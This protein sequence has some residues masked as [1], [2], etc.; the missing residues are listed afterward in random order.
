MDELAVAGHRVTLIDVANRAGVSPATVSRVLNNNYPVAASTRERVVEA[1]QHFDYVLNVHAGALVHAR[2]GILGIVV[3]DV[4]DP[5][6]SEIVRGAQDVAE[7]AGHLTMICSSGADPRQELAYLTLLRNH[8]ADA[9]LL[10]GAGSEQPELQAAL[11][12]QADGIARQGSRLVLVGRPAPVGTD[13]ASVVELDNHRSGALIGEHLAGLGHR[14]IRYL[15]G[16]TGTTTTSARLAGFLEGARAGGVLRSGVEVVHGPQNRDTGRRLVRRALEDG[17]VFSAVAASN[18]LMAIGALVALRE[19]GLRVPDDVSVVGI[20]DVPVAADV[21]PG[22]STVHLP[23]SELG[24]AAAEL[25]LTA[26]SAL[27]QPALPAYLVIR[28]STARPPAA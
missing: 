18:D 22:L 2:S 20:D 17:A 1:V 10:V 12:R 5:F 16:P 11:A 28:E 21:T 25:A 24:A 4:S 6:F 13:A 3:A 15:A 9:V 23:L 8:R 14:R 27:V 26:A 19:A 7:A